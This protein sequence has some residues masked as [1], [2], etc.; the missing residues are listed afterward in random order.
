[1]SRASDAFAALGQPVRLSVLRSLIQAGTEGLTAGEIAALHNIRANTLSPHLATLAQS[2]LIA[3]TREGRS[4]RYRAEMEGVRA[5]IGFLLHDCCGGRPELCGPI[6]D[7]IT[8]C[9]C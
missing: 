3:A 5:L 2:G 7:E 9:P 6:L 1:M 4:I 8:A